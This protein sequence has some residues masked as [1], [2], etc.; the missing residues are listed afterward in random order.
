M[1]HDCCKK[2][3]QKKNRKGGVDM[4]IVWIV[5][6]TV[7]ILGIAVYFGTKTG[8]KTSEVTASS[9]VSMSVD[10]R[11]YDWGTINY[12]GGIVS[13]SF[14]ITNTSDT[15]LKF[16]DVKTSCMCTTA[17]LLS[18]GQSSKK[19]GMH[20]KTRSVFE[21]EPGETVEVLVEFDPAF[22][23]PSGVGPISRT[24]TMNTNDSNNPTLSFQLAAN[25]I[26]E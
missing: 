7:L 21:V 1:S 15:V 8:V 14:S 22:H 17:Q 25:V 9:E 10:S 19:F 20:E 6:A 12:G 5:I 11:S 23:G 13:K 3:E 16:Y 26:K 4:F 2:P 18:A 24:V